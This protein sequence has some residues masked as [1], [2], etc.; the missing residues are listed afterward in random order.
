MW[1]TD[2]L[3]KTLMLGKSEGGR[4]KG[5]QKMRWLGG[6]TDAMDMSLSK[7]WVL[8]VDC[9]LQSMGLQR[10]GHDWATELNWT[11]GEG[12]G[13]SLQ[14]FCLENPMDR[15]AWQLQSIGSQKNRHDLAIKQHHHQYTYTHT[16]THTHTFV[17]I[18][19]EYTTRFVLSILQV[20]DITCVSFHTCIILGEQRQDIPHTYGNPNLWGYSREPGKDTIK[21]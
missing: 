8:V 17:D 14:Y 21:W 3:E 9:V 1:R 12:N 7:L 4:K 6:I 10:V 20:M 16:H 5:Q 18:K 11:D 19:L 15:G 2:S 13:K